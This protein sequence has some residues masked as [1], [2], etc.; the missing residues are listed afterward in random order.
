[1]RGAIRGALPG[2]VIA[3]ERRR[4]GDT[5]AGDHAFKRLEPVTI[6]G[7]ASVWIA[8]ELRRLDFFA[9][10][11]GPLVPAEQPALMERHH[12]RE[13]FR[14]PRLAKY[15]PFGV[16][17]KAGHGPRRLPRGSGINRADAGHG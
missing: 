12:D 9:Q 7:L 14:L 13:G 3:L 17:G 15:R 16:A 2:V 6:V 1:M 4:F 10:H 8:G 5:L 11:R